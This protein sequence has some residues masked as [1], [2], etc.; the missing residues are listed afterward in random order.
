MKLLKVDTVDSAREKLRTVL[1]DAESKTMVKNLHQALGC[2]LSKDIYALEPV[3]TF[4]RSTVDGYAVK[5]DQTGGASESLPVFLKLIGE[6][7]MGDPALE[8]LQSGQCIYVP[9]G[10]MIPDGAD[11]MIMVEYCEPFSQDQIAMYTSV[12]VGTGVVEIGEDM[13][14]GQLVLPK[15]TILRPQEIGALAA[16]GET[17][18]AVFAPWKITIISTGDELIP[19]A[20]VP[21]NGQV[22]DINT[23]GIQAQAEKYHMDIINC[24]VLKDEPM[25]LK[26][27]VQH[28]L[29]SSDVVVISGGSS[30]GKKD[31]THQVIDEVASEGAFTHGLALKPGKPTILGYDKPTNTILAG[32][33]GH[34]AAAMLVFELL[35]GW[36]FKERTGARIE[37]TVMGYLSINLP[38][39]PGRRTCQ[40]VQLKKRADGKQEVVPVFGK[41]GMISILTRA[42]GYILIEENQEGLQKGEEVEVFLIS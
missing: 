32:L 7:N 25:Q 22:R 39:A 12:A 28:A 11:A 21:R 2:Y 41:S 16:L 19:P 27:K 17:E 42:D 33:P 40:L 3:P 14:K 37:P 30:Q 20:E 36:L 6:V 26:E 23:Y 31:A 8:K 38:G 35:I 10:G 34:P 29:N 9:T 13:K 1:C 5:A 18:V 24:F 15:G 4:R